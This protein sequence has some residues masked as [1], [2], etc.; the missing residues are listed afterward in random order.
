MIVPCSSC[1]LRRVCL[2]ARM[3]AHDPRALECLAIRRGRLSTGAS[4]FR[5]GERAGALYAIRSGC[6]KDVLPMPDGRET[7]LH[8][9]LPGEV[10][11]LEVLAAERHRSGAIAL[12]VT[13]Y[14]RI[15]R[16][17]LQ[18]ASR[19]VPRIGR[20]L[21]RVLA[22]TMLAT[23][24]FMTARLARGALGRVAG[25]LIEVSDRLR[26]RRLDAA[27]FRLVMSRHDIASYLGLTLETVSRCLSELDRRRLIE[28]R[29]KDVQVL[30][31]IELRELAL[32]PSSN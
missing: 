17:S 13:H 3:A 18:R 8:F 30:R 1:G 6:L 22:G 21:V 9:Y 26:G 19:E 31:L 28:I 2:A 29:A 25:F 20:E 14:C 24:D 23:R 32:G 12:D 4:L 5:A 16:L 27:H 15:S 11:G 7:V 10:A